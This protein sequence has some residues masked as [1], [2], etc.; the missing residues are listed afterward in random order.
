[1]IFDAAAFMFCFAGTAWAE[2]EWPKDIGGIP[3]REELKKATSQ[4][5]GLS[6]RVYARSGTYQ[7]IYDNEKAIQKIKELLDLRE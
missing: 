5:I 2:E 1:M 4:L 7:I 6:N 3:K